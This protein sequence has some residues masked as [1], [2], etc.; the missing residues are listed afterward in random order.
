[1]HRTI[2]TA[3]SAALAALTTVGLAAGAAAAPPEGAGQGG[4]P[5]GVTCQQFGLGVLRDTGVL[6]AVAKDGLEY[7]IGSGE[8]IPFSTVLAIHRTDPATANVVLKDYAAVLLPGVEVG[9]AI[10]AACPA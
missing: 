1:M 10:D 4:K 3:A 8:T 6:T 9:A 2:I 5:A 7:P